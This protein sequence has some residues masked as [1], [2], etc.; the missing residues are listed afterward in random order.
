MSE[1]TQLLHNMSTPPKSVVK[2]TG[3]GGA[4]SRSRPGLAEAASRNSQPV[5][6]ST[7]ASIMVVMF[8]ALKSDVAH[9]S[10]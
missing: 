3:L 4:P 6:S 2:Y 7:S 10:A 8:L 1:H 5:C 9:E